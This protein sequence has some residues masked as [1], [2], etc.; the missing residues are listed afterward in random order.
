ML[1]TE[2]GA[3]KTFVKWYPGY[4]ISLLHL[5]TQF[6]ATIICLPLHNIYF[7]SHIICFVWSHNLPKSVTQFA[8]TIICLPLDNIYFTSHIIC[9]TRSYKYHSSGQREWAARPWVVLS[10]HWRTAQRTHHQGLQGHRGGAPSVQASAREY[11]RGWF[12]SLSLGHLQ[13][14]PARM[15]TKPML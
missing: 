3:L 14:L 9:L 2:K 6:T 15:D 12:P 1:C 4:I 7:T 13:R 8:V 5:I 10:C 11:Y